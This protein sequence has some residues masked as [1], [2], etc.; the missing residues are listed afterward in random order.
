MKD[1]VYRRMTKSILLELAFWL[2]QELISGGPA[3][4]VNLN[5]VTDE[6]KSGGKTVVI[7]KDYDEFPVDDQFARDI[8]EALFTLTDLTGNSL[9]KKVLSRQ[10]IEARYSSPGKDDFF[11]PNKLNPK[12]QGRNMEVDAHRFDS[13]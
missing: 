2:I 9:D 12:D 6:T 5:L 8:D 13:R 7:G 10:R 4:A 1:Y 11:T 3:L